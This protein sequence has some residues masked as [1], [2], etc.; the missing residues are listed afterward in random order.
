MYSHPRVRLQGNNLA[1]FVL[2]GRLPSCSV[3]FGIKLHK[4]ADIDQH[5]VDAVLRPFAFAYTP[6]FEVR[7]CLS[8]WKN[9]LHAASVVQY[10]FTTLVL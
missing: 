6:A 10:H 2:Q 9:L 8:T 4:H 5:I 1:I 3:N 7:Q